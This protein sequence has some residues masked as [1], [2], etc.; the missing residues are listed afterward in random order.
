MPRSNAA[1]NYVSAECA[2]CQMETH[3]DKGNMTLQCDEI[4][5]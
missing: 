5:L 3:L 1:D 2:L 4:D